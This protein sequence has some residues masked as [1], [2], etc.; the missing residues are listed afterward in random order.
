MFPSDVPKTK[1]SS[2][3]SVNLSHA[4]QLMNPADRMQISWVISPEDKL[5]R[6]TRLSLPDIHYDWCGYGIWCRY[7]PPLKRNKPLGLTAT[8][9]TALVWRVNVNLRDICNKALAVC[10]QNLVIFTWGMMMVTIWIEWIRGLTI[11]PMFER[12][13]LNTETTRQLCISRWL[14]EP[15]DVVTLQC[16]IP[17]LFCPLPS[18]I[19]CSYHQLSLFL[20]Y[21]HR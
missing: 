3:Q 16:T 17:Q 21:T 2:S 20:V 15:S 4:R 1:A 7:L 14:T 10:Q 12:T 9:L 8:A 11:L 6:T 19:V 5:Q 13:D 18:V